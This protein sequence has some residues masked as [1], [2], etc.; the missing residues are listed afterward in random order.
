MFIFRLASPCIDSKLFENMIRFGAIVKSAMVS[1]GRGENTFWR[2][3][4]FCVNFFRIAIMAEIVTK[5]I[6]F[7]KY[8]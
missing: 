2:W 5:P 6:C 7:A 8:A 3:Y 4:F 1:G